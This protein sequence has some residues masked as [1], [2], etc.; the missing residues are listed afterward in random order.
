MWD[1]RPVTPI[2]S[3]R[4]RARAASV[5]RCALLVVFTAFVGGCAAPGPSGLPTAAPP[6]ASSTAPLPTATP[7]DLAAVSASIGADVQSIRGL[8]ATSPVRTAII[9]EAEAGR[10]LDADFARSH[11]PELVAATQALDRALGFLSPTQDLAALYRALRTSQVAGF[12]DP[13]TKRLNVVTRASGFG[14]TERVTLAHEYDHALQDQ[15]FDLASLGTD[16]PGQSD[17]DLARLALPEGDAT[18]VMQLWMSAHLSTAE[19]LAIGIAGLDPSQ[20]AILA[21]TPPLLQQTLLFPYSAGLAW[22]MSLQASGGWAA[23]DAAYRRPP[24]ST[25]QVLHPEKYASHEA[26]IAVALPA[27]LA[28]AMGR[29]WTVALGDTLGEMQLRVWLRAVG[30]LSDADAATAAAGWGGDRVELLQGPDGRWAV[31]LATA[32]DTAADAGE[33]LA[34]ARATTGSLVAAHALFMTPGDPRGV[35]VVLAKIDPDLC[36]ATAILGGTGCVGG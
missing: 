26:P 25:E 22:V 1:D 2:R 31:V 23:V 12:Y 28:A 5:A 13:T 36:A 33:F 14:P 6:S 7:L 11:P 21:S 34:A 24:D 20:L 4:R 9:G 18:L 27:G 30:K 15:H 19:I 35:T 29:G 10:L 32:W 8:G 16:D 3:Q 17:R